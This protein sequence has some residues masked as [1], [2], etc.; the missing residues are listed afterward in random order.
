MVAPNAAERLVDFLFA[1]FSTLS[2][3]NRIRLLATH[4]HARG[5]VLF[6]F[7]RPVCEQLDRME[8]HI[9]WSNEHV[10]EHCRQM[11]ISECNMSAIVVGILSDLNFYCLLYLLVI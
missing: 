1:R 8:D 11:Y 9:L 7:L 6:L 3:E 4:G 5:L 2:R 10:V